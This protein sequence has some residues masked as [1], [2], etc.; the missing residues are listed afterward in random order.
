[1]KIIKTAAIT[2]RAR[3]IPEDRGRRFIVSCPARGIARQLKAHAAGQLRSTTSSF[4]FSCSTLAGIHGRTAPRPSSDAPDHRRTRRLAENPGG[5]TPDP[6]TA[7]GPVRSRER[8]AAAGAGAVR[9]H[10]RQAVLLPHRPGG[11]RASIAAR[12]RHAV[13]GWH[14]RAGGPAWRR[15]RHAR[16]FRKRATDSTLAAR[17]GIARAADAGRQRDRRAHA[18]TAGRPDPGCAGCRSR[19]RPGQCAAGTVT[20]RTGAVRARRGPTRFAQRPA[21]GPCL[22]P[23]HPSASRQRPD[24]RCAGTPV[25]TRRH[26]FFEH[27]PAGHRSHATSLRAQGAHR[28]RLRTAE[29]DV[30]DDS[31]GGRGRRVQRA[32]SLLHR[33]CARA[34]QK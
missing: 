6:R 8:P 25:R 32:E 10:G 21:A 33:V 31:R 3:C 34:V 29:D 23:A 18:A 24:R 27:V 28:A 16:L 12:T 13:A 9:P 4:S 1:V 20:A 2:S 11:C 15:R 17:S 19:R 14:P 7:S 5:A 30:T 22:D 26:A